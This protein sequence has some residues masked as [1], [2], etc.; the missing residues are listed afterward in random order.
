MRWTR[1]IW[2]IFQI[3]EF[4]FDSRVDFF[5]FFFGTALTEI[6]FQKDRIDKLYEQK[7]SRCI[8]REIRTIIILKLSK[9]SK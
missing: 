8:N 6:E 7:K 9:V 4:C 2:I 1:S 5:F 3:L